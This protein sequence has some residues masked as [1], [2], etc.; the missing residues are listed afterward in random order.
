MSLLKSTRSAQYPLDAE[1]TFTFGDS[2]VDINGVTRNFADIQAASIFE[3]IPL[4]P[5]A[6]VVGGDI[7]VDIPFVGGTATTLQV[8]DSGA[9]GRYSA[10]VDLKTA[11]R[12]ALTPTGFLGN[13]ENIR[14]SFADTVAASTAGQVTVRVLYKVKG[15]SQEVVIK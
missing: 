14:G 15:R 12:T 5:N 9:A 7:V 11:G 13:G 4:P 1:F 2:M 3:L 10:A 6:V 8:G